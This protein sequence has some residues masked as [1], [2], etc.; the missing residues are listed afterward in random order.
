M[1]ISFLFARC[2]PSCGATATGAG[3]GPL[4]LVLLCIGNVMIKN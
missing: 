3:I 1:R 2:R 4:L